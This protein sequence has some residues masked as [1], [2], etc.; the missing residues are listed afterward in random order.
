MR[1]LRHW[2]R[3]LGEAV[4]APSLEMFKVRLDGWSFELSDLL[5]GVPAH[6]REVGTRLTLRSFPTQTIL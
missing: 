6:G 4:E 3:W 2:H 1:V 5:G